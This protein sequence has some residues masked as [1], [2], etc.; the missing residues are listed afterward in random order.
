M[1]KQRIKIHICIQKNNQLNFKY[2]N[3]N[4]KEVDFIA[5]GFCLY[6]RTSWEGENRKI[7]P[8]RLEV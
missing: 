3:Q 6:Y 4:H 1:P 7:N 2:L 5:I 8:K